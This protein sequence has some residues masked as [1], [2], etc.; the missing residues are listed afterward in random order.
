MNINIIVTCYNTEDHLSSLMKILDGFTK[1][2]PIVCVAYSG[3]HESFPCDVRLQNTGDN[4]RELSMIVESMK[5]FKAKKVQST[6]Y[7]KLSAHVWPLNEDKLISIFEEMDK[8]R[9][10]FAGNYWHHNFEGSLSADFFLLNTE[11]GNIFSNVTQVVNDTEVTI[12]QLLKG[13]NKNPYII[14]GRDPVFWNNFFECKPLCLAM[15]PNLSD[16]LV[17]ANEI[18]KEATV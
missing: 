2:K 17:L 5:W 11:Y 16:N 8:V 9:R 4:S 14:P 12:Y 15:H 10:P 3:S 13:K 6:R 1:I 18:K 7:L